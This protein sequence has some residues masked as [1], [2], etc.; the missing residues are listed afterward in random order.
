[1]ILNGLVLT[2]MIRFFVFKIRMNGPQSQI[3]A[4]L[5]STSVDDDSSESSSTGHLNLPV[6]LKMAIDISSGMEYLASNV[7]IILSKVLLL[8]LLIKLLMHQRGIF[9]YCC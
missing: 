3:A 1:M 8:C 4:I 9:S 5:L 7:C 6:L 2:V